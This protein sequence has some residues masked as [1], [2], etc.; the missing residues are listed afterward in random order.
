MMVMVSV[1]TVKVAFIRRAHC[2]EYRSR[3]ADNVKRNPRVIFFPNSELRQQ[4]NSRCRS[5]LNKLTS[6]SQEI[7]L[8][9]NPNSSSSCRGL[10]PDSPISAPIL[11]FNEEHV[12]SVTYG[13]NFHPGYVTTRNNSRDG[14]KK[15]FGE[16]NVY[17]WTCSKT[18]S[19]HFPP[20]HLSKRGMATFHE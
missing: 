7:P 6:W 9:P 14:T 2:L 13:S 5:S 16:M 1:T 11:Y 3:W 17:S 15:R 19:L 4:R 12:N 10:C 20:F 8:H 18:F